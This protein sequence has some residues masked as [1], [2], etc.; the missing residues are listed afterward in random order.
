MKDFRFQVF[1]L[2]P[3]ALA[4]A[5][6]SVCPHALAQDQASAAPA[7]TQ[8]ADDGAKSI[9]ELL[10]I[11][12]ESPASAPADAAKTSNEDELSKKLNE[13]QVADAF[14]QA[15]NKMNLSADLLENSR[16]TGLGTQRTQEEILA[17]LQILLDEA[18]KNKNQSMSSSQSQQDQKQNQQNKQ[19]PGKN[20]S[21]KQNSP[22]R[23]NNNPADST[24]D[25][26]SP[27]PMQPD[28]NTSLEETRTQ[29][30]NLPQRVRDMLMQGSRDKFSS[31]YDV[32]TQE[33]YKR[34]AED[35]AAPR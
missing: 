11:T 8:P 24:A 22:N 18:R 5:C 6:F 10:G 16:D 26:P 20:N 30:G 7:Q 25:A 19:N 2:A 13:Q 1:R 3:H 35:A 33:Y 31:L 32:L 34:L 15:I 29:W 28:V 23:R 21:Q 27:P 4:C 17:K 12:E 14:V 9:D